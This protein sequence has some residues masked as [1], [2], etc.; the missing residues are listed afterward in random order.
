VGFITLPSAARRVEIQLDER[1]LAVVALVRGR[2]RVKLADVERILD[3]PHTTAHRIARRLKAWGLV[4]VER[5]RTAGGKLVLYLRPTRFV[6]E[7]EV[8]DELVEQIEKEA[9]LRLGG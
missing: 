1:E 6:L 3:I 9:G 2:G 7:I 5:F 8:P 4:T